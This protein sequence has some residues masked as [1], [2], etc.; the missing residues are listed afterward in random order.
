MV[1]STTPNEEQ[2]YITGGFCGSK[3]VQAG[4]LQFHTNAR[5][6]GACVGITNLYPEY[7]SARLQSSR[8]Y[9]RW[10]F[11]VLLKKTNAAH[12]CIR[13]LVANNSYIGEMPI[14]LTVAAMLLPSQC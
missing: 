3:L 1:K 7:N 11:F 4:I 8:N 5:L 9:A 12:S 14:D 10:F 6:N 13:F 2:G